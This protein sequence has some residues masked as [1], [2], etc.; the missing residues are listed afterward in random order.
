MPLYRSKP[1]L[2]PCNTSTYGE[3]EDY[4]VNIF[5]PCTPPTTQA[6]GS[7][8]AFAS[9]AGFTDINITNF[10]RGNGDNVL[11]VAKATASAKVGPTNGVTYS[12]D[13]N[14]GDVTSGFFTGTGN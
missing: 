2:D 1:G 11:I 3:T 8:T 4:M 14:F 10:S 6:S 12:A 5:L 9:T 7:P 13:A